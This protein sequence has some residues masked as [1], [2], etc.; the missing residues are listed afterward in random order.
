MFTGIVET[1]GIIHAINETGS[2]KIFWIRSSL[3]S[4][5]KVDQSVAH[6]G[7]CLTVEAIDNE[8]HKVSVVAETLKKTTSGNWQKGQPINLERCLPIN[9]RLDGHFVQGHVDTTG[10]VLKKR[11]L[12]GSW[13]FVFQFP[14]QFA[15]LLIEK[16]SIAVNGTSLTAFNVS[17]KQFEVAI[18][19]YTFE[20]TVLN[21][22]NEGDMVNLEFDLLGKYFA[23]WRD[24]TTSCYKNPITPA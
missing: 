16:G 7:V 15:E 24:I 19:P 23:R 22:V 1:T 12:G 14:E 20:N 3:A 6:N 18:I 10:T 13:Q 17:F 8:L 2:N 11:A 9:G 21:T 5:L 4:E